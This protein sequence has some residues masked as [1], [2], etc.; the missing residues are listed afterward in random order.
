MRVVESQEHVATSHIVDDVDEQAMLQKLLDKVKPK[1]QT[2]TE[3]MYY[4]LKT[5]FDIHH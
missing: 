3:H 4:L 2:G 5:V 1:Y